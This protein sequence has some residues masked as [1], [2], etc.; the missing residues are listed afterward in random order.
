MGCFINSFLAFQLLLLFPAHH[1]NLYKHLPSLS[2][3]KISLIHRVSIRSLN[4]C[5]RRRGRLFQNASW[6][7]P[8]RQ[9]GLAKWTNTAMTCPVCS[10]TSSAD[11]MRALNSKVCLNF[12]LSTLASPRSDD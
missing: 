6:K 3:W 8:D 5:L 7:H 9:P 10:T 11:S 4:L 2:P 1:P 12:L